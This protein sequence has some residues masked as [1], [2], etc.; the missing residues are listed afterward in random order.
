MCN[1]SK[2]LK[3]RAST[4]PSPVQ[5]SDRPP[6]VVVVIAVVAAVQVAEF[7]TDVDELQDV[8][9]APSRC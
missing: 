9:R 8:V 4:A 6:V 5:G 2:G 3:G 1:R 7:Y